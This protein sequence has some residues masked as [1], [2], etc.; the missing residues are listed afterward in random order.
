MRAGQRHKRTLLG[1]GVL[2]VDAEG[3]HSE[4]RVRPRLDVLVPLHGVTAFR[5]LE[6][7]LGAM[8]AHVRA[9]QIRD[10]VDYR[11]ISRKRPQLGVLIHSLAQTADVRLLG[12]VIWRQV[13]LIIGRRKRA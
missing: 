5:P 6:V 12:R 3:E 9:E 2:E 1:A 10:E 8:E 7:E 4:A 13:E 11:R